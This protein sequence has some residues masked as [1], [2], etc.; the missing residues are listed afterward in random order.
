MKRHNQVA[1]A[2]RVYNVRSQ[3]EVARSTVENL[4]E[5]T[6]LVRDGL[7]LTLEELQEE[8]AA[9]EE[10]LTPEPL[11][12]AAIGFNVSQHGDGNVIELRRAA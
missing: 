4:H 6:E 5:M 2:S 1:L 10:E 11:P 9:I 8:L 12:V 7:T 3:I